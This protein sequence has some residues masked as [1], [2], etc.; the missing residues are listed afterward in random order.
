MI[1]QGL[2]FCA[3]PQ[4]QRLLAGSALIFLLPLSRCYGGGDTASPHH[5]GAEA[6]CLLTPERPPATHMGQQCR[7]VDFNLCCGGFQVFSK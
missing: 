7:R 3:V 6:H 5:Q 2:R 4:H 1:L